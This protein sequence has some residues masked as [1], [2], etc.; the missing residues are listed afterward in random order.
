MSLVGI[1]SC[2]KIMPDAP[3]DDEILDG[4][5]EGLSPEQNRIFLRVEAGNREVC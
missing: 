2:D 1:V 4:P 5:I 3:A